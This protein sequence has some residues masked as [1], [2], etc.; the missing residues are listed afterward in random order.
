MSAENVDEDLSCCCCGLRFS[1]LEFAK[2]EIRCQEIERARAIFKYGLEKATGSRETLWVW[3]LGL[4]HSTTE[5]TMF[6]KQF[7]SRET[8]EAVLLSKR[9][10]QYEAVLAESPYNYDVWFDYLKMVEQ[11]APEKEVVEVYERAI[12]QVPPSKEKRFWRRYIYFWIYY[13]VY[14][15]VD[16][17]DAEKTREVYKKCLQCIPHK[18]FTFGKVA[19]LA[20]Y[21]IDLDPVRA[22]RAASEQSR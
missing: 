21:S 11:E 9:K 3:V 17:G 22:V 5:Y 16:V 13:A 15:E 20:Q 2:F 14:M 7:G 1:Y 6:E 19:V 10:E 12:A 4:M 18:H 8:I